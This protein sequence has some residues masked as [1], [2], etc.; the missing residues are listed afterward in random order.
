ME[1]TR[2]PSLMA[3]QRDSELVCVHT[4]L[5]VHETESYYGLWRADQPN[6]FGVFRWYDGDMYLGEWD[7]G[8]MQGYGVYSYSY[9]GD[10]PKD[11]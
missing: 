9:R 1:K 7:V 5:L 2:P 6:S 10:H 4:N 3:N 8:K 11:R